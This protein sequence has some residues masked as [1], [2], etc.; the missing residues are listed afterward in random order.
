MIELAID[1]WEVEAD[2]RCI[3]TNG[4]VD[5][6]RNIMGGGCAREAWE[7]Y[8]GIDYDYGMTI[9]KHGHHV[10]LL[11]GRA[12]NRLSMSYWGLVMFPTK[13]TID[14]PASLETIERSAK[15]LVILADLYS[16]KKI[17][18]PRPGAGLGGLKWED[19]K[20]VLEPI[21]DDRF[22]IIDFPKKM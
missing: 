21:F 10:F 12:H 18:V 3:T 1:L 11:T 20:P 13:E 8:P 15:E 5:E 4:T 19:V 16:W 7:R 9:T 14:Q 2:V 17:A 22:L 6:G